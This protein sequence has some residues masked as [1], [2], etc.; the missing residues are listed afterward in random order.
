MQI[1]QHEILQ[2][3]GAQD[4][5]KRSEEVCKSVSS[6]L[7]CLQ[8]L[9]M[10]ITMPEEDLPELHASKEFVYQTLLA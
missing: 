2:L 1:Y 5:W 10:Y 8:D 7:N 9:A 6:V 3:S 4:E